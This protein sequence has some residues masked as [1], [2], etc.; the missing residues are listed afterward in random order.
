MKN[1]VKAALTFILML[2]GSINY[3]SKAQYY[4]QD[5]DSLIKLAQT[6]DDYHKAEICNKIT[7]ELRNFKPEEAIK[8]SM[9]ALEAA[10]RSG[11]YKELIR[12]YSYIGVCHRNIGN[13]ADALDYYSMGLDSAMKY[14]STEDVAYAYN[15]LGNAYLVLGNYQKAYDN[16]MPALEYGE[17]LGNVSIVGYACLNLG[18]VYTE[19]KRYP[20]AE[21]F[22]Q[23]ALKIRQDAKMPRSQCVVAE[24]F[25]GDYYKAV[26]KTDKA[27]SIYY[28]CLNDETVR[29]DY[30]LFASIYANLSNI[31]L[32]VQEYDSALYYGKLSLES[33]KFEGGQISIK[34]AYN[35]ISGVYL[36]QG[37][38]K[39][40]AATYLE[41]INY[42]DS[43]FGTKLTEKIFNIKFSAEQYRKQRTIDNLN[44]ENSEKSL[45]IAI[46]ENMIF[47]L[48]LILLMGVAM[49]IILIHNNKKVKR[50][51]ATLHKQQKQISDSIL[52]A[53]KIQQAVLPEQT[54]FGNCFSDK[55]VLYKP[56]D[57]VSGD[58]YW[59]YETLDYEIVVV[60]DCTGHGVP[61]AFM[62]MLGASALHDIAVRGEFEAGKILENL[63]AKVKMLL[64][65]KTIENTQKD[66]MDMALMV[67]NRQTMELDYSG[68]YIPLNYIRNNE[69]YSLKPTKNPIGIYIHEQ[70]FES[71]KIQLQKGDCIYLSSD[72]FCSQ[73]S[74]KDNAKL[75]QSIY[76]KLLLDN[77][78]LPMREQ[79]VILE[80]FFDEWK[81]SKKQVD[82]ILVAGFRV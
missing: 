47:F 48:G 78:Q 43:A 51:N 70:P 8:F 53:Q 4:R 54:V 17:K 75:R 59:C 39:N 46:Q 61:G 16:L 20:L 74:E 3:I 45:T 50:L 30:D 65:Q 73:F 26:G 11:N 34:N 15:N 71:T 52:Y 63:R 33:A 36:A 40:A 55:F 67:I 38:F 82:D 68:A 28:M 60:A 29:T 77:H 69:L 72:G 21:E 64:K 44:K 19:T 81:G 42:N 5:I 62:S 24:K 66:G 32:N 79:G 7:W 23:K 12:A 80:K 22:L 57:V 25:I 56:R 41:Q 6:S 76:K 37:E 9:E 35:A 10:Q 27:K 14:N 1:I 49:V 31:Y 13:Y 2:I 18:R 58:F